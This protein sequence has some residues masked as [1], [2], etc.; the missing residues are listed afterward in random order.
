MKNLKSDSVKT[1]SNQMRC[2]FV[3]SRFLD[4]VYD[5][6]IVGYD[7]VSGAVIYD[8]ENMVNLSMGMF[9]PVEHPDLKTWG[10][11]FEFCISEIHSMF[12]QE[13]QDGK[14]PPILL[15]VFPED[16]LSEY[17]DDL[18]SD[19]DSEYDSSTGD[20]SKLIA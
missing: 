17:I 14:V 2:V 3:D 19:G 8:D 1:T 20:G 9:D 16:Y 5:P 13:C 7:S 4:D 18:Q 6:A 10:E 11:Q 15:T 12:H